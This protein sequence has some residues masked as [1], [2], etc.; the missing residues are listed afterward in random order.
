MNRTRVDE[1]AKKHADRNA[2]FLSEFFYHFLI[3]RSIPLTA[4]EAVQ[5]VLESMRKIKD[6]C[7]S[8]NLS[9]LGQRT[10]RIQSRKPGIS[11]SAMREEAAADDLETSQYFDAEQSR[12]ITPPKSSQQTAT[13]SPQTPQR[14]SQ[15]V[16]RTPQ[17]A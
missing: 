5:K 13:I 15:P 10:F 3:T 1:I 7:R 9:Q 14:T 8:A 16:P 11:P 6:S 4:N 17:T 2:K 12:T